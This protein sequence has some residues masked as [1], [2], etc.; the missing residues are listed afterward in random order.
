VR[1][2]RLLQLVL[3]L[4]DGR[5]STAAHLA[6]R[7]QVSERTVLRDLDALSGAGVPVYGVRGP[8]GGFQ[9]LDTFE[10]T[11]SALPPGLTAA[12]GQ[13]RRVRV[14]L[15]PAA[16]QIALVNGAPEGWRPRPGATP[17]RD[18]PDWLEGSFR[19]DSYETAVGQL[20]ALGPDVEVLLP[21]ELRATM[22]AIGRRIARLHGATTRR[23]PSP[24]PSA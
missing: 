13:L 6:E 7:L 8:G 2:G 18:R 3:I 14:R 4:Q 16:L 22:A 1:A 11:V 15:A 5:R 24:R 19:F 9:L 17:T 12:R 23:A 21:E 10:R 20:L